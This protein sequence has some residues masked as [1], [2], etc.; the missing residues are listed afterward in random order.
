[1][2]VTNPGGCNLSNPFS[3]QGPTCCNLFSPRGKSTITVMLQL[4]R[5]S[6]NFFFP[7]GLAGVGAGWGLAG[8]LAALQAVVRIPR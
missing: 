6:E 2:G 8:D 1:M 4:H 7:R 3:E 5:P